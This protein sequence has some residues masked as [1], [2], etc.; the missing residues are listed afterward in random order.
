[1]WLKGSFLALVVLA[2]LKPTVILG[3]TGETAKTASAA[4]WL[5]LV[6]PST[7][8]TRQVRFASKHRLAIGPKWIRL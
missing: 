2:L 5:L 1:M 6:P 7:P 8:A 3:S 4:G